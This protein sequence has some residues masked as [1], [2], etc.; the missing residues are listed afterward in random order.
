MITIKTAAEIEK[1]RLAGELVARVLD[2][3]HDMIAPGV[4][5]SE[6]DKAAQSMIES[7]IS[8]AS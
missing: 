4:T 2:M 7:A 5:P 6:L 3:M 8:S 1:M